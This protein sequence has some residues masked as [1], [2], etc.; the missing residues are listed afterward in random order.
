MS[1]MADL[2]FDLLRVEI[3]EK[4]CRFSHKE[5]ESWRR[6]YETKARNTSIKLYINKT[7]NNDNVTIE[8]VLSVNMFLTSDFVV[9]MLLPH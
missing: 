4:T 1:I 9:W 7:P 2:H 8:I 6:E 5:C 3:R